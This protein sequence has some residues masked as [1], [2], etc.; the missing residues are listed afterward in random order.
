MNLYSA[1][2]WHR[3][4]IAEI[5]RLIRELEN[6]VTILDLMQFSLEVQLAETYTYLDVLSRVGDAVPAPIIKKHQTWCSN[7]IARLY[8]RYNQSEQE[9]HKPVCQLK[10]CRYQLGWHQAGVRSKLL[11]IKQKKNER[12]PED[13]T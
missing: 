1:L 3:N 2:Q 6:Q 12:F 9:M 7:E 13:S 5:Q 10:G 11:I 4:N 8:S